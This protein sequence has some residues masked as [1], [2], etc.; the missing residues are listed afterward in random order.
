[1]SV[2]DLVQR[3]RG[4][5][6]NP[7]RL[8]EPE[9]EEAYNECAADLEAALAEEGW[10]SMD[11][12]PRDGTVIDLW[13][14]GPDNMVDFYSPTATKVPKKPLRHGRSPNWRWAKS[15]PNPPNW[16]QPDGLGFPLSPDVTAIAWM[17]LPPP[18]GDDQ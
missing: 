6:N 5:L 2:R 18:P 7:L 14:E 13:I 12:A 3:W 17:P 11:S 15:G 16:Y 9:V 1:M 10:R 8:Y 4:Y